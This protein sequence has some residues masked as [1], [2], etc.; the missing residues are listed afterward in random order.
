VATVTTSTLAAGSHTITAVYGGDANYATSTGTDTQTVN[1]A[2]TTTT[3]TSSPNPSSA[4]Q[5]VTFTATVTPV[6]PATG[7]P[8]G[9]VTFLIQGPGGG[10]FTAPLNAGGQA[11]LDI[12]TLDNSTHNATATYSGD[13]DFAAS[14]GSTKQVV[15]A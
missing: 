14:S 8:T 12:S 13:A 11:V 5:T 10:T 6:P 4:G 9:T 1:Q 2:A 7:I 3:V 15:R